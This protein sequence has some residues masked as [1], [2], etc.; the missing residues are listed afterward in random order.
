MKMK[1]NKLLISGI[2]SALIILTGCVSAKNIPPGE[3]NSI[4]GWKDLY[5]FHAGDSTWIVHPVPVT[6]N[7]FSGNIFRPEEIRKNRQVHI[8]AEPLSSVTIA[9]GQLTVP[10]ENIVKVENYRISAAAI[11]LSAGVAGL[12][13]LV[14]VFL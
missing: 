6:G 8:Y 1:L 12:L 13:F 10:M 5:Y 2:A 3:M 11:L 7:Y 14:P 9:Q 4:P